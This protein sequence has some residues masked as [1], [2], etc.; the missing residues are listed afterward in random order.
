M[1]TKLLK[2]MLAALLLLVPA[3][4]C[5]QSVSRSEALEQAQRF[6]SSASEK[7]QAPGIRGSKTC[8]NLALVKEGVT[9]TSQKPAYYVFTSEK[10]DGGFVIVSGDERTPHRILGYSTTGT[11]PADEVP[12]NMQAWLDGY[13]GQIEVLHASAASAKA[14]ANLPEA[15]GKIIVAPLI[16]TQ[17]S[18]GGEFG[19]KTPKVSGEHTPAGCV[20]TAV[21]QIMNYHRWPKQG[22]GSIEYEWHN[23][24][25][26][27]DFDDCYYDWDNLDAGQLLCDVGIA[28]RTNYD[29]S[30]SSAYDHDAGHALITYF[31]YDKSMQFHYR[32]AMGTWDSEAWDDMLREELDA[33]RPVFY[34]G[35]EKKG[36]VSEAHAFVCDG[37]DSEGYF[38]F[39]F[40]WGGYGDGWFL[41]T[42]VNYDDGD[43]GYNAYQ[44]VLTHIMPDE[45]GQP[46]LGAVAEYEG[47]SSG[48][49][50]ALTEGKI[51]ATTCYESVETGEKF[52]AATPNSYDLKPY[53][54]L[55]L[56]G[57]FT[58]GESDSKRTFADGHVEYTYRLNLADGAYKKYY[59]FR[60]QGTEEWQVNDYNY[61]N[62]YGD[63]P[64]ETFVWVDVEGDNWKKSSSTQFGDGMFSYRLLNDHE[65]YVQGLTGT[66]GDTLV[67][68]S[69]TT[70]RGVE[71][72]VVG[73]CGVNCPKTTE[74]V[75]PEKMRFLSTNFPN[76]PTY[77]ILNFSGT[78]LTLPPTLELIG[79]SSLLRCANLSS[80]DI[81]ASVKT[82]G[83]AAFKESEGLK[84]VTFAEG[85]TLTAL[86][87][88]CFTACK[89]LK[90][91]VLPATLE[92][93]EASCFSQ[94]GSMKEIAIP[95]NVRY[96]G[97]AA[98]S[99]CT[100]LE[101][102][103][104][105]EDGLL[106]TIDGGFSNYES[107]FFG[108][109]NLE[110]ISF[111]PSL[112]VMNDC[113]GACGIKYADFSRTQL[114]ELSNQDDRTLFYQCHALETVLLPPT[115]KRLGRLFQ[116]CEKVTSFIIP[117]GTEE[118]ES[119]GCTNVQ[120]LVI[121]ASVKTFNGLTCS[122]STMVI[123]EGMTPPAGKGLTDY[124]YGTKRDFTLYVPA[125]ALAAYQEF[126]FLDG[127]YNHQFRIV[128]PIY[129][130]ATET[131]ANVVASAE[132]ATVVGSAAE[133][134]VVLPAAVNSAEGEIPVTAIADFAFMGNGAITSIDIPASVG[135][136]GA[137]SAPMLRANAPAGADVP[138]IGD[139]AFAYCM[140]MDTVH[141]HWTE[142]LAVN[143][144]VFAGID[145]SAL[146]LIVPD[147]ATSLYTV[148]DVWKKF[149]TVVEETVAGIDSPVA[150]GTARTAAT[151]IYNLLGQPVDA[152]YRGIVIVNGKKKFF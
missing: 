15:A 98:F 65:A 86:P 28:C 126:E 138:A 124:I 152:S 52:Y 20:P 17:W 83:K 110:Y 94:C 5:A 68:P 109:E 79:P 95:A 34:S 146:T 82:L 121:P 130:M 149:G 32:V 77:G 13:A 139:R 131:N 48:Y 24:Y 8:S 136:A 46:W 42:A 102:I 117:E 50:W 87:E 4:L 96:I 16:T 53:E 67:I 112:K 64:R 140:N 108:T 59:V 113:F 70:Y 143:A 128:V 118:I 43:T 93:I 10:E 134:A 119:L 29:T 44:S 47:L 58:D 137:A 105:A 22:T 103:A 133:G 60:L 141:V 45:G 39:N 107:T 21:A 66:A 37:Y 33:R 73:V 106:E 129:E 38:H 120:S 69:K 26:D 150:E 114:T 145:L 85:S 35:T 116:D 104:F 54:L 11:F 30:G 1:N 51:E 144:D 9:P 31:G 148:A 41:T 123:C 6:L 71:Y 75:F 14:G 89:R 147:G 115:I 7:A 91:I 101:H 111:P 81:P 122:S 23:S 27:C 63:E 142:P 55:H 90:N 88:E 2:T 19:S 125:G 40:G 36:R 12:E 99:E 127:R 151:P 61:G 92:R 97:K 135:S 25:L 3:A 76:Q 84:T 78:S 56:D 74:I 100:N 57:Y 49:Y 80:L 62:Q 18:Q 132:S 72:D